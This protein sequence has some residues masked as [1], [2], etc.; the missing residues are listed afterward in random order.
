M[1]RAGLGSDHWGREN[2]KWAGLGHVRRVGIAAG[3][4]QGLAA[5]W[6]KENHSNGDIAGIGATPAIGCRSAVAMLLNLIPR[7]V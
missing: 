4:A 7:D 2:G 1:G 6:R 5:G 3:S